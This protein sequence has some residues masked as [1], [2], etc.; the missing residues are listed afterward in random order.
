MRRTLRT[1]V[2]AVLLLGCTAVSTTAPSRATTLTIGPA[3]RYTEPGATARLDGRLTADGA[4][5]S[6]AGLRV[7]RLVSGRWTPWSGIRTRADGTY[8]VTARPDR[9]A[10]YRV[11]FAGTDQLLPARSA[12]V[13]VSVMRYAF[14]LR[15]RTS[16]AHT[17]ALYPATDLFAACGTRVVAPVDGVVLEVNRVD[18]FDPADP[19][20]AWK[21]GR[22][23]SIRGDDGVRHYGAHFEWISGVL[24]P[25]VRVRAGQPIARVGHTGNASGICHL[26][27]A[28][29]P[30]CAATGDWWLRR[31]IV[32]PWPYLDAWRAGH[33]T[34]PRAQ[35]VAWQR[36]QGCPAR[37]PA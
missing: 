24:R 5:V 31:G 10:S 1:A 19:R 22:F 7:D 4:G 3:V 17:H 9:T 12:R 20:G 32:Y 8:R 18:R 11:R 13:T 35:V 30:V 26:H 27:Y 36:D 21:G 14:P 28:L 16:Y 29:S 33:W 2:L 6:G 23:V 25:G 15:G 34:S 37:P